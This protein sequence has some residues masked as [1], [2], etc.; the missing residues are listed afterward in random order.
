MSSRELTH[1]EI[2]FL[3]KGLNFFITFKAPPNKDI[4]TIEDAVKDP[5][6]EEAYMICA[7]ISLA[8]QNFKLPK[9]N[10]PKDMCKA[11]NDLQSG[12]SMYVWI[13]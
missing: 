2:D 11:L 9:D 3:A 8:L 4:A 12:M 6:K 10:L 1:I 13:I 5:E 7:K